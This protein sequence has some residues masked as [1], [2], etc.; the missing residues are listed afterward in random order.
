MYYLGADIGGSAVK[1]VAADESGNILAN[2]KYPADGSGE[3]LEAEV[4]AMLGDAEII[5][6]P[7]HIF[8]TGAGNDIAE[9]RFGDIPR[10][11]FEEFGCFARGAQKLSGISKAVVVS[12]GTGT[13]FVTAD[14]DRL[15]HIGGS[16]VG[17][18]TLAGLAELTM[19]VTDS[20]TVN[21]L[22]SEGDPAK[23]DLT[24]GDICK[25]ILGGLA[26]NVTAANFGSRHI[27]REPE[28]I[29]AGLA[30]MI[31]QTAGV[32]AAF[33]CK[34]TDF[35]KAVFVGAMSE[36]PEGK[37]ILEAVGDLHGLSFVIPPKAAYAGALGA[38]I[39]GLERMQSI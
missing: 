16:G 24:M 3:R 34:G 14:G 6:Q 17:G 2:R 35:T 31:F 29:A 38:V 33:A 30:N 20:D 25:G 8:L 10:T 22:I 1:L 28:H 5:G 13:A 23:V 18:G 9:H 15:T 37:A 36:L 32:M 21:R 12:I 26:A 19:N 11:Y 39:L 4:R 7:K 27:S